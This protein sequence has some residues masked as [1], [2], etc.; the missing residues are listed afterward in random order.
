MISVISETGGGLA[1]KVGMRYYKHLNFR[2]DYVSK[3][4]I[5][6]IYI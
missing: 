4:F 1:E 3:I 6:Y 2:L 5:S